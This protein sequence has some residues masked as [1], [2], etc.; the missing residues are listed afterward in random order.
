MKLLIVEDEAENLEILEYVLTSQ[1]YETVSACNG[2]DALRALDVSSDIE[3]IILDRMMPVMD[4]LECLKRI[5]EGQKYALIPVIMQTAAV[6][7]EEVLEGIQYGVN[8]YLEKPYEP[9]T[10]IS[11][12]EMLCTKGKAVI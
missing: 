11:V 8:Y 6:R 10:L 12:V 5:R 4:G 7:Q 2:A 9:E 1:G 3:G